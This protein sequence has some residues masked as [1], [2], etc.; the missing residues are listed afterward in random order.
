MTNYCSNIYR[1]SFER[2]PFC[3]STIAS[4]LDAVPLLRAGGPAC[5]FWQFPMERKI[6][7]LGKQI[8]PQPRLHAS[9]EAN[10]TRHCKADLIKS[11][12]EA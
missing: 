5:V 8:G 3:L 6:G 1:G 2:L 4:L 12:G 11:L 10:V 9:S 7:T